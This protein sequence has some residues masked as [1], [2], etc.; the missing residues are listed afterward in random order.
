MTT[1]LVSHEK[2]IQALAMR[3]AGASVQ[4]IADALGWNSHQAASKAIH[5]AM[6]RTLRE[7]A[8]DLRELEEMR[9]D[10]MLL[11]I[12]NHVKAGN[13]TAIDRALKIQARRAALR[14][15]DM[16]AKVELGGEVGIK[17]PEII[18]VIKNYKKDE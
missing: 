10:D 13:L 6:K 11:A 3:K 14:G 17:A 7:G 8:D 5:S 2:Q 16:P 1:K 9:L 12:A 4:A 15:L 18:E